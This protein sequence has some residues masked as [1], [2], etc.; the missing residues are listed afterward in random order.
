MAHLHTCNGGKRDY[1]LCSYKKDFRK[2]AKRGMLVY[3]D[4][5]NNVI[6]IYNNN[7]DNGSSSC[8]RGHGTR[9]IRGNL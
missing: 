4:S 3:D 1:E 6:N 7:N 9:Q 2:E 8:Q 5:N